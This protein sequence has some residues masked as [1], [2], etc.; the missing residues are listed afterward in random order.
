ME[1]EISKTMK[2]V[3]KFRA[4]V[5]FAFLMPT[6]QE[7]LVQAVNYNA[8][9]NVRVLEVAIHCLLCQ[10]FYFEVENCSVLHIEC[11]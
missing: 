5:V 8:V 6:I 1:I 4:D 10:M 2:A 11:Q 9:Y 3:Q 7:A